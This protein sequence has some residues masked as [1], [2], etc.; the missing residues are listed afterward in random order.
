MPSRLGPWLIALAVGAAAAFAI[1]SG[2]GEL[3]PVGRGSPAPE[4]TLERL[5]DGAPVSLSDLRGQVVLVNFWATWCKPCEDEMPAME[6]LYRALRAEGFELLAISV[7]DDPDEV[8]RFSERLGL[9]FPILLDPGQ[10]VARAYLTFRFPESL[11]IDADGVVLERYIGGKE[12]DAETYVERI[13]RLLSA[14]VLSGSAQ[15][16]GSPASRWGAREGNP[17]DSRAARPGVG[18][19]RA[20]REGG[21][22]ALAAS[23]R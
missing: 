14:G 8:R 16:A 23:S 1:L 17:G 15:G 12:W 22:S 18:A 2:P 19:R 3:P 10:R 21:Y 5:A 9:S 7:D 13:R 20:G 6:R 4:F 11:L